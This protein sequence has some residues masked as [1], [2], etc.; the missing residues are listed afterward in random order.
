MI[1]KISNID[2]VLPHIEG[3]PEFVVIEKDRCRIIDYLYLKNDTFRGNG[4]EFRIEC[5][6]ISFDENGDIM[7][8][9]LH[10]F[11]NLNETDDTQLHNLN[12]EKLDVT[13][14]KLDGSMIHVL[15]FRIGDQ[16]HYRLATRKGITDTSMQAEVFVARNSHYINFF[17]FCD[18]H[19]LTPIFEWI[20]PNNRIVVQYDNE[21]LVLLAMR[22]KV[23]GTYISN[24]EM[25][26]IA[27]QY[28]IP[29][30][31]RYVADQKSHEEIVN[32]IRFQTGIEGFVFRF[33]DSFVK[34]K[35][36][37][38]V[39]LH[40]VKQFLENE[41]L[42]V[43]SILNQEVDDLKGIVLK[44]DLERIREFEDSFWTS[45]E[46]VQAKLSGIVNAA[47][48]RNQTKKDF[49]LS[50]QERLS[51]VE[52][53]VAFKIFDE[54]SRTDLC[55][56]RY[57]FLNQIERYLVNDKKWNA[58]KSQVFSDNPNWKNF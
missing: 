30:V 46:S 48:E 32:G 27:L 37:E 53:V 58:F 16:T 17:K 28:E 8:R 24:D 45:F 39:R 18:Q 6:G 38:Y 1:P 51:G 43:Q 34:I 22:S 26:S 36:E 9:P 12:F 31:E 10:K 55:D 35:T 50:V 52:K 49:V 40:L 2:D 47:L 29:V 33:Q 7:S 5:R 3:F 42:M 56:V 13:M 20:S 21:Q 23:S 14:E 54:I 19:G 41:R 57:L 15:P 11:F 44:G 4:A 25:D